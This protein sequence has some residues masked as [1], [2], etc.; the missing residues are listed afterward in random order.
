MRRTA[1]F[2]VAAAA[3]VSYV[4]ASAD[5]AL[6][7]VMSLHVVAETFDTH[8]SAVLVGRDDT[9]TGT[10]LYFLTSSRNLSPRDAP[11]A[12]PSLVQLS[13]D[14]ETLNVGREDIRRARGGIVD[15]AVLRTTVPQDMPAVPKPV[16]YTSP[17]LDSVFIIAVPDG[18]GAMRSI[19]QHV[20]FVSTLFVTGDRDISDVPGCVGAPAIAPDG[21]F[22]V[23][24]ECEP[25]RSPVISLL[26]VGQSLLERVLPRRKMTNSTPEFT[27]AD[28]VVALSA[29][30][31]PC[32]TGD[33]TVPLS[34]SP[35]EVLA[36][37]TP[38]LA[39]AHELGLADVKIVDFAE[40]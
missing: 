31:V 38:A 5:R 20:R 8:G 14:A 17:P 18:F 32:Q 3:A 21:V 15:V 22:G 37:V 6:P 29:V 10:V 24:H 25:N 30:H 2:A 13:T 9:P 7:P 28:K 16:S 12:S 19:P 26:A 23:V 27:V 34:T 1:A 35:G 4:G 36:D 33:V 11:E 40:G 39:R